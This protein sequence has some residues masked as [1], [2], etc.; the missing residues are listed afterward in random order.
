MLQA[1]HQIPLNLENYRQRQDSASLVHTEIW[2]VMT[3]TILLSLASSALS[4]E[5][6]RTPLHQVNSFLIAFQCNVLV[7]LQK[8]RDQVGWEC[9]KE[10]IYK[11]K[12]RIPIVEVHRYKS[13]P[14]L[15][16]ES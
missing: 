4:E 15:P 11:T 3:S 7:V 9:L 10:F 14:N 8:V 13:R 16:L 2:L 6:M 1:F 5:S 12:R